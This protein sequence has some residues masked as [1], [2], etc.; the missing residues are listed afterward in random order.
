MMTRIWMIFDVLM[1]DKGLLLVGIVLGYV[2]AIDGCG[3]YS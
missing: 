2:Y 3:W 1:I